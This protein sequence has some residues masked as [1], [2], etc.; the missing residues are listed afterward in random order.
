MQVNTIQ[1][2]NCPLRGCL[3]IENYK[4]DSLGVLLLLVVQNL[5]PYD[6]ADLFED[7]TQIIFSSI[8]PEAAYK[9]AV[10]MLLLFSFIALLLR[11]LH[12]QKPPFELNTVHFVNSLLRA[13]KLA[14][15]YKP[16]LLGARICAHNFCMRNLPESSEEILQILPSGII[17]EAT[18]IN[19]I[20]SCSATLR[21][22]RKAHP[23]IPTIQ[24]KL[25][26]FID[27]SL[28]KRGVMELHKTKSF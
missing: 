27:S 11:K 16:I 5:Y 13:C 24:L 21:A 15:L 22:C 26:Q 1:F 19:A 28:H 8:L 14:E 18:N 20:H 7:V 9:N 25:L 3:V 4:C 17:T 10:E 2:I 6:V 23:H 12:S